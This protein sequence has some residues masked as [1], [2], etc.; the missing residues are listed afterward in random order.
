MFSYRYPV[1]ASTTLSAAM[2]MPHR[3]RPIAA[4][5]IAFAF[6]RRAAST[7]VCHG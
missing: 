2:S 4:C 7:E 1:V 5:H 3:V 6:V